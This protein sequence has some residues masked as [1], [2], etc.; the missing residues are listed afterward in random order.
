M[1][2]QPLYVF[3]DGINVLRLLLLGIGVI[4]TQIRFAAKF[5]GESEVQTDGLGMPDVEIAVGLWRKA[6]LH[7]CSI[8]VGLEVVEDDVADKVRRSGRGR[9]SHS[10]FSSFGWMRRIHYCLI[11]SQ[12]ARRER[13]PAPSG[14][15][16]GSQARVGVSTMVAEAGVCL[17]GL[18]RIDPPGV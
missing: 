3:L 10:F 14:A 16:S 9:G 11:L 8:F 7:P 4:E 6:G 17:L 2:S 5:I 1:E 18:E 13:A 15:V 12:A